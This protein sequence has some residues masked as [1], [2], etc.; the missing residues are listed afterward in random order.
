[1]GFVTGGA[2]IIAKA[3][4]NDPV[5]YYLGVGNASDVFAS[6]QVD[7]VG[8]SIRKPMDTGYPTASDG[9]LTLRATFD[10]SEANFEWK[11]WGVFDAESGGNML[12][13]KVSSLGT[14]EDDQIWIL[15]VQITI[16]AS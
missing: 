5:T 1:M 7:L 4:S 11:E 16:D 12:C 15:I 6:D 13:R 8:D 2:P 9:V 14:K 3:M 10:S